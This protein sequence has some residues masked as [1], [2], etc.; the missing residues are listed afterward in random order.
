MSKTIILLTGTFPFGV[1]ESF[2]E[3]EIEYLAAVVDSVIIVPEKLCGV[4]RPLPANVR[5]Y[6]GLGEQAGRHGKLL[7]LISAI[8]LCLRRAKDIR[9]NWRYFKRLLTDEYYASLT[10]RLVGQLIRN[11]GLSYQSVLCYSYWFSGVAVGLVRLKNANNNLKVVTRAH[12]WDLYETIGA[13]PEF[14]FRK[15]IIAS[16]DAVFCIAA[17]GKNHLESSFGTSNVVLSRLGVRRPRSGSLRRGSESISLVS[18]SFIHRVK[19]LDRIIEAIAVLA[20][21]YPSVKFTWTHIGSGASSSNIAEVAEKCFAGAV[22]LRYGFA[23]NLSNKQVIEFYEENFVD[24]FL[25][26]SESEGLPVSMME[27]MSFGIP[28]VAPDV[29]G[30]AEIVTPDSGILLSSQPTPG[31]VADGIAAITIQAPDDR[32]RSGARL[33]WEKRFDADTNYRKFADHLSGLFDHQ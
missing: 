19:R 31:E 15:D 27:A 22:N 18:C 8:V 33:L 1:G 25:N 2:L 4:R 3:L 21:R 6:T 14:P 17:H 11:E 23:G 20:L 12:R 26:L 30:I 10:Q 28:V 13:L 5:L 29:G 7:K 32:Y 9:F 24:C 16:F